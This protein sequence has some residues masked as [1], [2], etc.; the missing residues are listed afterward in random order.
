MGGCKID[1]EKETVHPPLKP[2][3]TKR[4]SSGVDLHERARMRK[5]T[6]RRIMHVTC[7]GQAQRERRKATFTISGEEP[8]GGP[9]HCSNRRKRGREPAIAFYPPAGARGYV[10]KHRESPQSAR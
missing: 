10:R 5:A 1:E 6:R 4:E 3:M 2:S 7:Q 8:G 9:I